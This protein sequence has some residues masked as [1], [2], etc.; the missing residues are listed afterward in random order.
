MNPSSLSL[1]MKRMSS[2]STGD[3]AGPQPRRVSRGSKRR[4]QTTVPFMSRAKTPMLPKE[5]YMRSPSVTG[6]AEA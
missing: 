1:T 3:A 4:F 6:V 5:A 2:Y